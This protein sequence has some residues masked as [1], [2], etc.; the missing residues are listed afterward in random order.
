MN[1]ADFGEDLP[2]A[3]SVYSPVS[4]KASTAGSK[5]VSSRH[6][7]SVP[8]MSPHW[9]EMRVYEEGLPKVLLVEGDAVDRAMLTKERHSHKSPMTLRVERP[10]TT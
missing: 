4:L 2:Y 6:A 7:Y 3:G 8:S 5:E 9:S 10:T 1:Y